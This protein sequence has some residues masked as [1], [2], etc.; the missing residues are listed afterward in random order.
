MLAN[1]IR[2]VLYKCEN[3]VGER[4]RWS[5]WFCLIFFSNLLHH[6]IERWMRD[7]GKCKRSTLCPLLAWRFLNS[8]RCNQLAVVLMTY[9]P[10][11]HLFKYID[12]Y[13]QQTNTWKY[14]HKRLFKKYKNYTNQ[15]LIHSCA[16]V[17]FLI[18]G[19][20]QKE[21]EW[22]EKY[23]KWQVFEITSKS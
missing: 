2:S 19:S 13:V 8:D 9:C 17:W 5:F 10:W 20:F 11:L 18:A 12:E 16:K 15:V 1:S 4:S 14:L 23:F 7:T 3:F 22:W 21:W 6:G